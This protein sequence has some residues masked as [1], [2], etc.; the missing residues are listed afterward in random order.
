MNGGNA[1]P[2]TWQPRVVAGMQ[3]INQ[4]L[5]G[6]PVEVGMSGK[7]GGQMMRGLPARGDE[8]WRRRAAAEKAGGRA[9]PRSSQAQARRSVL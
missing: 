2:R 3:H 4:V 8:D 9:P 5:D 1:P 6:A 7:V